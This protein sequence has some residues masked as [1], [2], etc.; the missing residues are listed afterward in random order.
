M[1]FLKKIGAQGIVATLF[2]VSPLLAWA[3]ATNTSSATTF[4]IQNP[5][6]V[7]SVGDFIQSGVTIFTYVVILAAVLAFVWVGFQY[8]L[9]RGNP[10]RMKELSSWLLAI[11]IGVAIV[12]GARLL[13]QLVINTLSASGVV[14]SGVIQSATNA[15]QK[16]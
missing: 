16:Q 6:K 5:L 13:I 3:Q 1:N 9:A 8:I 11:V 12:I 2:V 10:G 15:L 14:S 4:T 7:N